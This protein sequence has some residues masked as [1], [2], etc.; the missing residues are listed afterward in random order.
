MGVDSTPMESKRFLMVPVDSSAA[1]MPR[2]G[3]TMA[4]ATLFNSERFIAALLDVPRSQ[5][6]GLRA[7]LLYSVVRTRV[8][9]SNNTLTPG[10]V[11]PSRDS[12]KAPPAV[13]TWDNRPV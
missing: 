11:L 13:D 7:F 9:G 1:R 4:S 8:Y 10:N 2:P 6:G 3:A 5:S 12:R